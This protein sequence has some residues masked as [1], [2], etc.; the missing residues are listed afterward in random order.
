MQRQSPRTGTYVYLFV[1]TFICIGLPFAL[2]VLATG[3]GFENAG[4]S[5][6]SV[7]IYTIGLFP[8][9]SLV[10]FVLAIGGVCFSWRF[11]LSQPG[12]ERPLQLATVCATMTAVVVGGIGGIPIAMSAWVL[13][14]VGHPPISDAR[15][16]RLVGFHVAALITAV[17]VSSFA[18][19]YCVARFLRT[20]ESR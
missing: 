1:L 4:G 8:I 16:M 10:A 14:G 9:G 19:A 20:D 11:A 18:A 17:A 15:A 6:A 7:M 2:V 3:Y 12:H 5:I 13:S